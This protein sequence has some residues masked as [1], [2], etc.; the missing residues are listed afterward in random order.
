MM[1]VMIMTVLITVA[2]IVCTAICKFTVLL[3][4]MRTHVL[5]ALP[6]GAFP[7]IHDTR[8]PTGS[9]KDRGHPSSQHSDAELK[10]K[11]LW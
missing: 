4:H 1:S 8:T 9:D 2:M 3:H 6:L 7:T 11:K 5:R 10:S